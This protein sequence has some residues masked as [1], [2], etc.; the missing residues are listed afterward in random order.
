MFSREQLIPYPASPV[1]LNKL[2]AKHDV[3]WREVEEVF[4]N[5]PRIFRSII[6]QYGE[7]RYN[8]LGRTDAG[9]YLIVF[10]VFV[11][12]NKAKVISARD[13]TNR[14]HRKYRRK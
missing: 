14:E 1:I 13:M 5:Q 12:P 7:R 10:F 4:L 3:D 8:A 6:D 9:R 2:R 11:S